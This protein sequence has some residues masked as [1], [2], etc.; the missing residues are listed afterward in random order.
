MPFIS[1]F[2]LLF[3]F[4]FTGFA[5]PS[6]SEVASL[7]S[8]VNLSTLRPRWSQGTTH[9]CYAF[10]VATL[11][12]QY[13]FSHGD[14]DFAHSTSPLLLALR[15]IENFSDVGSSFVGGKVEHAVSAARQF[16]SCSAKIISDKLGPYSIDVLLKNL[17]IFYQRSLK[18]P[19]TKVAE[20]VYQFLKNSGLKLD[21]LPVASE[22][23]K[24]LLLSQ[25][26]FITKILLSFCTDIKSLDNLPA[27]KLLF[28]PQV[29]SIQI[30]DRIHNLLSAKITL[31][32]NFCSNVV[33][34][35][36]YKGGLKDNQW[37]CQDQLNHS[38]VVV[39][40]K[41][42]NGQCQF[43]I[44]DTGCKGYEKKGFACQQDQYWLEASQLLDNTHGIFWL[45]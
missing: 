3:L 6:S 29:G 40:R 21:E 13:R 33:T 36:T 9:M 4:S 14:K 28:Q 23:E 41:M 26:E 18:D 16:G 43:L 37:H 38:A 39:G 8:E 5:L 30:L 19:K 10:S 12:D 24:D 2:I 17:Q 31:G 7:C 15:T 32:I 27:L 1:T 25:D 44:Q 45:D 11:I 34:N 20:K 35:P 22:I 42:V